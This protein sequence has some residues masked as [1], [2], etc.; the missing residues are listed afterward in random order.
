M[1]NIL[2][3]VLFLSALYV[4]IC[5]CGAQTPVP[6]T[7]QLDDKH[8]LMLLDSTSA[9]AAIVQDRYDR[10]FERVQF[11]EMT[12]QM[13]R[14]VEKADTREAVLPFYKEFLQ[15]DV[16]NFNEK[17]AKFALEVMEKAFKTTAGVAAN[18][19]PDTLFLIKT[20]GIHYGNSVYYT[21]G[22]CIIIPANELESRKRDNFTTTMFHE[23][24]HV[25]SRLHPEK[26]RA[27]YRLIGFEAV[28]VD[29]LI[30]PPALAARVLFNPDG[31]DFGQKISLSTPEGEKIEAIPLIYANQPAYLRGQEEFF[32]Y[33]EFNLYKIEQAGDKV[34]SVVTAEDGFSSVLQVDKLPDFFQQIKDNT[35]YI[36][37]PD[38]VLADNFSFLMREV[39]NPQ[40]TAKFSTAGRQLLKDIE[41]ILRE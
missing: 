32:S 6:R 19:F 1:K 7:V 31:V 23:L 37:H 38:E 25:Y 34:W 13:K 15:T 5:S 17:E 22:K 35:G 24:F 3:L 8:V 30:L 36:I 26:R 18:L 14:F 9:A 11:G 39:T 2:A 33:V 28:G 10:Y 27:L 40:Y 21:R 12:I 4:S 16:A 29:N 41:A 20:K